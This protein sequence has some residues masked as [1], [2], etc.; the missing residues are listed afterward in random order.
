[1]WTTATQIE[2]KKK[3]MWRG[4]IS[5]RFWVGILLVIAV[6]QFMD[7]PTPTS[8][9]LFL[10]GWCCNGEVLTS[11]CLIRKGLK[12]L[13][14]LGWQ[15][16]WVSPYSLDQFPVKELVA[17]PGSDMFRQCHGIPIVLC[18]CTIW[19]RTDKSE[20]QW[21][22]RDGR[23]EGLLGRFFGTFHTCGSVGTA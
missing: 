23:V 8:T 7:T 12:Y 14:I 13:T 21:I 9:I 6:I 22:F 4:T 18:G 2:K 5:V 3:E 1:M 15:N 10:G 16:H 20:A 17:T 11:C 19:G